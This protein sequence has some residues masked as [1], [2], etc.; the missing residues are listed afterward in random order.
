MN[1]SQR[2]VILQEIEWPT[3]GGV[4]MDI[5]PTKP[6]AIPLSRIREVRPLKTWKT[7]ENTV[8]L[9]KAEDHRIAVRG[10]LAEIV[11]ILN[12]AADAGSAPLRASAE[13]LAMM[14]DRNF[15][16]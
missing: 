8:E 1:R 4:D 6:V 11:T 3:T 16:S 12:D 14:K 15:T 10:T 5:E 13:T 2:F 7:F 9:W